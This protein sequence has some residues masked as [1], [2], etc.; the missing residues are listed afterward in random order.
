MSTQIPA[1]ECM[2]WP[3]SNLKWHVI[4]RTLLTRRN[5]L[6]FIIFS[7]TIPIDS[8]P[9]LW[10]E[11]HQSHCCLYACLCNQLHVFMRWSI[12]HVF[13]EISKNR[14]FLF[15]IMR[16]MNIHWINISSVSW[17]KVTCDKHMQNGPWVIDDARKY[18]VHWPALC[19]FPSGIYCFKQGVYK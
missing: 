17:P 15:G 19:L 10:R 9:L 2:K 14:E 16:I 11:S 12:D 18:D 1:T 6:V 13:H 5:F 7:Y 4:K 8:F 3:Q